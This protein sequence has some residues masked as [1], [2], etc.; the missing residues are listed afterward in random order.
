MGQT[1]AQMNE[2]IGELLQSLKDGRLRHD[3]DPLLRWQANN[4][5]IIRNRKGDIMFDKRD[6][7]DKIDGLVASVMAL[8]RCMVAPRRVRGSLFTFGR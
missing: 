3:G 4:A 8:R 5:V 6:S 1:C 2:P 7:D